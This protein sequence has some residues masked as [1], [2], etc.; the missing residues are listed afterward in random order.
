MGYSLKDALFNPET[1]GR[2][3]QHFGDAGVFAPAPFVDEVLAGMAP[4]ELKARIAWIAEVLARHLPTEF[5]AASEAIM[6]ALPEPLSADLTDDD[7]GHFIYAPLGVYVEN[8]GLENHL[9][10]S[11]DLFEAIT[12]RFSM[13]FSIRAFLNT[14]EGAVLERMADWVTHPHYHV[15]RLVS[16]GTRPRLP[17]GQ[18]VGLTSDQTMPLLDRLHGD[19]TRFVTRSVANHLNDVT[20]K[21]PDVVLGRLKAWTEAGQQN[22]KELDWMARHALRGLV[23]AGHPGAMVHLGYD[24]DVALQD[25][26]IAISPNDVNRGDA[27]DI[28]VSFR[29]DPGAHV[30]VDYV[31][32]F[33]KANGKTSPKVFK[34]KTMQVKGDVATQLLKRHV[35]KSNA[36]T[37]TL[38]PGDHA[39]HLQING[40]RRATAQFVLR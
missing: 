7:F 6:A 30:I 12:Q 40:V 32:D 10:Q 9:D 13:E 39:V 34:L 22:N 4:L 23:K 24:P 18:N 29:C 17:W 1:V 3:A 14:H 20:K 28:A 37:F 31:V 8:Q 11:L 33:V 21:T 38:H 19:K 2:L 35:F 27:A 15:R 25:M 16:E 5:D 26:S 36:T